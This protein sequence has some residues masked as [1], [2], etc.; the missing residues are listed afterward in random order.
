MDASQWLEH[1][2]SLIFG[3]AGGIAA[4]LAKLTS[5]LSVINKRL[6]TLDKRQDSVERR[7]DVLDAQKKEHKDQQERQMDELKKNVSAQLEMSHRLLMD[8][9]DELRKDMGAMRSASVEQ[10][11][12]L[13]RSLG[14]VEGTVKQI[15]R[16][17]CARSCDRGSSPDIFPSE[18]P[19]H[20]GK[21]R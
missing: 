17:G 1:A 19:T 4:G 14:E 10:Q 7:V 21:T 6:E 13:Q 15:A 18:P 16:N 12:E 11:I 2:V 5:S 3:G 20:R 9:L 8:K